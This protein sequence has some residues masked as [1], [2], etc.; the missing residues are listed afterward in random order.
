MVI[1]IKSSNMFKNSDPDLEHSCLAVLLETGQM[2]V[3]LGLGLQRNG[4]LYTFVLKTH[5]CFP[6]PQT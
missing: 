4:Q 1:S 3:M 5:G 6:L 2:V